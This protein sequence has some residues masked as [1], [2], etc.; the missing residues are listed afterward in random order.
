[1]VPPLPAG[2]AKRTKG[3]GEDVNPVDK[4]TALPTRLRIVLP[5]KDPLILHLLPT[6]RRELC[7]LDLSAQR[8]GTRITNSLWLR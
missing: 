3:E 8:T 5:R 1:V 7:P 2:E 6:G 4:L